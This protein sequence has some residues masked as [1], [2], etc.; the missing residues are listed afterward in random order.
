M[1][2]RFSRRYLTAALLL[3]MATI[4]P[5]STSRAISDEDDLTA[6]QVIARHLDSIGSAEARASITSRVI[7]GRA[8]AAARIGGSGQAEGQVVLASRGHNSLVGMAFT[9]PN[10]PHEKMGYDGKKLTVAEL[11]PGVRSELGKFFMAHEMPFREGLLSGTLST[12]WPLLNL[13]SRKAALKYE[14]TKTLQGHKRYVLRYETK[15]DSGLKTR[16]YF[17][18][19]TFRHVRTEY[20]H[21][22]IQ[23]MATAPGVTQK[24]GD[25]ITKLV[26]EFSDFK[27]V[28]G[29]S[30]PHSYKLQLSVEML[31]RRI[32]QDWTL[33]LS[34]FVANRT[35]DDKEFDVVAK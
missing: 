17:D 1:S 32:L 25:S 14:G 29:L 23:Q 21:R 28:D 16:L 19:E 13:P 34:Q 3:L 20:E 10:Y 9:V 8:L 24:Q 12:A 5:S 22:I 4:P 2:R 31:G 15:N 26:E 6:E 30:L 33:S 35:L 11:T 7:L 27:P 18:A